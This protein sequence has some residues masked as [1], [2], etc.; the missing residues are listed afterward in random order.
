MA[1]RRVEAGA[2]PLS[3]HLDG[4]Q[5]MF[6]F[7]YARDRCDGRESVQEVGNFVAHHDIRTKG[8][9]TR[10]VR[11]WVVIVRY[12]GWLYSEEKS[13]QVNMANLPEYIP[14]YL[15]ATT[16]R[17]DAQD[18]KK[19]VGMKRAKA[20]HILPGV[21]QKLARN[22]D[23]TY[24]LREADL[25]ADEKAL[26]AYLCT[27][28]IA[29]TAFDGRRLYEDFSATLKSHGLLR[30]EELATFGRLSV[31]I[32]LFAVTVMHNCAIRVN[33]SVTI[34]LR[35]RSDGGEVSVNCV[36]RP[37]HSGA[38]KGVGYAS[39][40]FRAEVTDPASYLDPAL[41]DSTDWDFDLEITPGGRL[42]PIR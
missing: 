23:G 31:P 39:S 17:I 22:N 4:G 37:H 33:E 9:V 27:V 1:G 28:V 16:R 36:F 7:G 29:R 15:Q 26:I 3:R 11:D 14:D 30:K 38:L 5:A 25:D 20:V 32:S 10:S 18:L 35:A 8:L 2:H 6:H 12:M 19:R 34:A 21:I 13:R 40:I 42:A 41:Q 24:R